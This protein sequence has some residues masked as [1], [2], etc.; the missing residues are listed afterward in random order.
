M[1]ED[2]KPPDEVD[3]NKTLLEVDVKDWRVYDLCDEDLNEAQKKPWKVTVKPGGYGG[4]WIGFVGPYGAT[5]QIGIEIDKG[6]PTVLMFGE[7]D[8]SIAMATI[9]VDSVHLMPMDAAFASVLVTEKSVNL[10]QDK[11][12]PNF[13][14]PLTP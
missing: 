2:V 6:N 9:G 13:V 5:R 8:E 1:T 14:D 10:T 11:A 7:S 3:I 4:L 12:A